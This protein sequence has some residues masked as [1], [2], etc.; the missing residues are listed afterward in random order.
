MEVVVAVMSMQYIEI[1]AWEGI[2]TAVVLPTHEGG[3]GM[4]EVES[5]LLTD[6]SH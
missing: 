6:I 4:R 3:G 2:T 1:S 5:S